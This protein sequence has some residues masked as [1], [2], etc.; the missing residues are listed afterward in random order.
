MVGRGIG[1][2]ALDLVREEQANGLQRLLATVDIVA[3]EEVVRV[4]REA[5]VLKKAEQVKV[6]AVKIA[7]KA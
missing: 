3:E 6:L 5:A 1:P 7:C 4:R 2:N